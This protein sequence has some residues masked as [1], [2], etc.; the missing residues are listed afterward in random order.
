MD[1][2]EREECS[3]KLHV[4]T[5]F[6]CVKKKKIHP[7]LCFANYCN[8][9]IFTEIQDILSLKSVKIQ[10]LGPWVTVYGTIVRFLGANVAGTQS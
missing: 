9:L 6:Q 7:S 8:C 5:F 3:H 4:V 10:M 2:R 1:L